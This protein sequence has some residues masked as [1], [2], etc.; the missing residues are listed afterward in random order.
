MPFEVSMQWHKLQHWHVV[1]SPHF[2]SEGFPQSLKKRRTTLQQ[3]LLLEEL[4]RDRQREL[5]F[6]C[7]VYYLSPECTTGFSDNLSKSLL[8]HCKYIFNVDYIMENL[9]VF[10]KEH[11]CDILHMVR[12]SFEDFEIND[13]TLTGTD[14]QELVFFLTHLTMNRVE[15]IATV[16]AVTVTFHRFW[17]VVKTYLSLVVLKSLSKRKL[18]DFAEVQLTHISADIVH[19]LYPWEHLCLLPGT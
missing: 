4:L 15:S 3:R 8:S 13:E 17:V 5:S 9:A 12:D 6:K 2:S 11:V 16:K 1:Y 10:K 14:N 19:Y 18:F 7:L